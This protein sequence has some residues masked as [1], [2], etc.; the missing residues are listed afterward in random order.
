VA[1]YAAWEKSKETG[2]PRCIN[3]PGIGNVDAIRDRIFTALAAH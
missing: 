2:A 1:Y 3:I